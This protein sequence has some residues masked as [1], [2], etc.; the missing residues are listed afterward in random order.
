[1][2]RKEKIQNWF[3]YNKFWLLTGVIL[4]GIL[5]SVLWDALGIGQTR[6]DY[7][8]AYIGSKRLSDES[9]AALEARLEAL[10][11]DTNRDGKVS[12]ELRQYITGYTGDLET[13]LSYNQATEVA[14]V[15]DI[16]KADSYFF[17]MDDPEKV[18]K[19]YQILAESD[20]TPPLESDYSAEG[21]AFRLTSCPALADLEAADS[22]FGSLFLGRRYFYDGKTTESITACAALWDIITEGATCE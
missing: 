19:A 11:Q 4:V 17:L 15:A 10:G 12:V 20:G 2:T 3:Y 7:I 5:G 18:Q 16:T 21:K 14:L 6:P 9:A 22:I 13:V 8:V 1:M